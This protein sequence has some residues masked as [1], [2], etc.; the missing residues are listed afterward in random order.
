MR[1]ATLFFFIMPLIEMLILMEVGSIIG[2]LP[3]IILVVLTAIFGVW[4]LRLEGIATLTRLQ[5]KI[6]QGETPG[7]ELLEGVMLIIGGALL[8]T[9]GFA[10]D[11][12]GFICLIPIFRRPLA[13]KII[14]SNSFS[15]FR[16]QNPFRSGGF[17]NFH[18]EQG[19]TI[20]GEFVTDSS[21]EHFQDDPDKEESEH[22]SK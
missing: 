22:L 4:L 7:S 21:N 18:G 1:K 17:G 15:K 6:H 5:K 12:I 13:A 2:P 19:N 9:P 8:L 14:E 16:V 3:T 11:L 10:T 20:D